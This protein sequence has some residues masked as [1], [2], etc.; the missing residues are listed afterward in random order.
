M[1]GIIIKMPLKLKLTFNLYYD[2]HGSYKEIKR[3][4]LNHTSHT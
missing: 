4:A 3:K 2:I 1:D